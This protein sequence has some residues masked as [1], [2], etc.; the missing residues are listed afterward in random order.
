[1]GRD[2][3][4]LR[5][6]FNGAP[7]LVMTSHL[8]SE[9]DSS[10]ERKDQ[11]SKVLP[12]IFSGFCLIIHSRGMSLSAPHASSG[13]DAVRSLLFET[14]TAISGTFLRFCH[15]LGHARVFLM[16]GKTLILV[17]LNQGKRVVTSEVVIGE[18]RGME[19]YTHRIARS[20]PSTLSAS[21]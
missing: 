19:R 2:L 3:T 12:T 6:T 5:C 17:W 13:T 11:F 20:W 18:G 15:G 14:S 1:M 7:L 4:S 9:K 10:E 21:A 16:P 8:E